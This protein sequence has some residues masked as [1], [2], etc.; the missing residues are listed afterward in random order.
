MYGYILLAIALLSIS[1][2]LLGRLVDRPSRRY[3]SAR[4]S[5]KRALLSRFQKGVCIDGV[6]MLSEQKS[7]EHLL[8]VAATGRGKTTTILLPNLVLKSQQ[9]DV[10]I[11]VTDPKGELYDLTH[12]AYR[13]AGFEVLLIDVTA[14]RQSMRFNPLAY[15]SSPED[16]RHFCTSLFDVSNKGA[17]TEGLWREGSISCLAVLMNTVLKLP[18]DQQHMG[19]VIDLAHML[20]S[21]NKTELDS[22]MAA[23]ADEA[24]FL[25]Y[26]QI[27]SQE[28]KI[29]Q[30]VVSGMHAVLAPFDNATMRDL[31]SAH[32]LDFTTIRKQPT[33]VYLKT[34]VSSSYAPFLTVMLS[35][36]FKTLLQQPIR[37][38]DTTLYV[39]LEEFGN[40]LP[41]ALLPEAVSLLRSKRVSL[42][43]V[44]QDLAQL[45][46]RY[47][48]NTA[49]IVT[50]NCATHIYFSGQTSERTL[51]KIGLLLGDSTNI[52]VD[53][54]SVKHVSKR[55]LM[56][57]Q[58]IRTMPEG[59]G[60]LI[61]ANMPAIKVKFTPIYQNKKLL[62][63]AG[64]ASIDGRL[65]V[66]Q[67][68][69][70]AP[71]ATVLPPPTT[72][73][74]GL[75]LHSNP[76]DMAEKAISDN[77]FLIQKQE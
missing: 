38:T 74:N 69:Q 75:D 3:G 39:F 35:K 7:C 10:S 22:L 28:V 29:F 44:L 20:S 13:K 2:R 59:R 51:R 8:V 11:C 71:S 37:Q 76:E 30:G 9:N 55:D 40:V 6:R 12:H 19:K 21:E 34:G 66:T 1:L 4:F 58:E 60:L 31:M 45:D 63:M 47:G 32:T 68:Q 17:T 15:L 50:T 42:M 16:V 56:T 18:S 62:K 52:E 53:E 14:P 72:Q 5:Q 70:K 43:F 41:I 54:N 26:Q 67:E 48:K 77:P 65:I 57:M 46:L 27:I 23:Y 49:D 61:Y 64:L 33:I 36:L 73:L 24:T 25:R